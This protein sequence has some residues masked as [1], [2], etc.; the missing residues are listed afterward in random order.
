MIAPY[1]Q[2]TIMAS[3]EIILPQIGD[4]IRV[5]NQYNKCWSYYLVIEYDSKT[6]DFELKEMS[7]EAYRQTF[8]PVKQIL[9]RWEI[10]TD[11]TQI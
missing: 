4:I 1:L 6:T 9:A 5:F 11:G 2:G 10:V 8:N 3:D 7:G